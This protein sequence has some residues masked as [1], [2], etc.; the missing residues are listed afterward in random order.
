MPAGVEE[1]E[2]GRV[3]GES[4]IRGGIDAGRMV[5]GRQEWN[6]E[7]ERVRRRVLWSARWV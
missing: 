2:C 1:W 4:S 7:Q 6:R 3:V 5:C